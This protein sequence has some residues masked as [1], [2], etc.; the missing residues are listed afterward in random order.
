[1]KFLSYTENLLD[2]KQVSDIICSDNF[3]KFRGSYCKVIPITWEEAQ[4]HAH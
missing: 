4:H 3:I 1:M 2:V